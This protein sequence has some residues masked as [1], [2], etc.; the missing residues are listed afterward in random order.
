[1]KKKLVLAA[2][3]I[4]GITIWIWVLAA[5][6]HL[7]C[8]Q[9]GSMWQTHGLCFW[10]HLLSGF[11]IAV[12]LVAWTYLGGVVAKDKGRRPAIGWVL[13]FFLQFLGCLI[14]LMLKRKMTPEQE[15]DQKLRDE[16]KRIQDR[17]AEERRR[18]ALRGER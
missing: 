17:E 14:L 2:L 13:G 1:M 4:L 15:Y 11:P 16:L 12:Y 9:A 8:S 7:N 3:A 6:A 10:R 18:S 5:S